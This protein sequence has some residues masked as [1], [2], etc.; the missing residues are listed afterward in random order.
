MDYSSDRLLAAKDAIESVKR[1]NFTQILVLAFIRFFIGWC[2]LSGVVILLFRILHLRAPFIFL[3]IYGIPLAVIYGADYANK[4]K[5]SENVCIACVD[6]YNKAGGLLISEYETGDLSW[7]NYRKSRY[8]VPESK[9]PE[10][11]KQ[12]LGILLIC[13]LFVCGSF[14]VPLLNMNKSGGKRINISRKVNEIKEQIE[15]LQQEEVI[16]SEERAKL[17][18]SLD[19]IEKNSNNESPGITFEA[20]DQMSD[21]LRYEASDE[22]KKRIKD[23]EVLKKLE[24][25]AKEA[26]KANGER[27]KVQEELEKLKK[28]LRQLGLN[29]AE[30]NDL[31]NSY[32]GDS[33]ASNGMNNTNAGNLSKSLNNSIQK[34]MMDTSELAEK[35]IEKNLIDSATGE[36]FK[37]SMES[38]KTDESGASSKDNSFFAVNNDSVKPEGNKQDGSGK[39]NN[40]KENSGKTET[41]NSQNGQNGSQESKEGTQ[42]EMSGT[43]ESQLRQENGQPGQEGGQSGQN[44]SQSGDKSGKSGQ[45]GE[46]G[47]SGNQGEGESKQGLMTIGGVDGSGGVS[48]GGGYTPMSFGDKTSDH[49]AKYH[50]ETLP[51]VN[52]ESA[53][54][55]SSLG[56]GI[57]DPEVNR[58]KENYSAGS[59]KQTDNN[60]NSLNK[61]NILPKHRNAVKNYFNQ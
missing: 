4:H 43:K 3:F 36:K 8:A 39:G 38:K 1:N 13:M 46:E 11:F 59:I 16:S 30:I 51:S 28:Q 53:P 32:L 17:E 41:E 22:M 10:D 58:D 61:K 15:L 57:A 21:K 49:N 34:K 14:Y 52:P 44:G 5:A 26:K 60:D 23:M 54:G 6:A 50:D 18:T 19:E 29:E 40:S 55:A 20:L 31:L 45:A 56:I 47:S 42:S 2:L 7:S 25:Y 37:Q 12:L 24:K 48:R 35:M 27:N 9:M 33:G